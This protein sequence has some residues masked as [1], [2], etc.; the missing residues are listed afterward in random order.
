MIRVGTLLWFL[1]NHNKYET[2]WYIIRELPEK[3]IHQKRKQQLLQ[4]MTVWKTA[5]LI[6]TKEPL[7]SLKI[8]CL[9]YLDLVVRLIGSSCFVKTRVHFYSKICCRIL[10]FCLCLFLLHP[11]ILKSFLLKVPPTESKHRYVI[12]RLNYLFSLMSK[13]IYITNLF[14]KLYYIAIECRYCFPCSNKVLFLSYQPWW[15]FRYQ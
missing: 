4:T 12:N 7:F 1:K 5:Y 14:W 11:S 2:S 3:L 15:R 6:W 9:P 8:C 13:G 10:L